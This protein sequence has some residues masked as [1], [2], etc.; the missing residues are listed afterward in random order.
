MNIFF[1]IFIYIF[2]GKKNNFSVIIKRFA[3]FFILPSFAVLVFYAGTN[4]PESFG[5]THFIVGFDHK[6]VNESK[7]CPA[8]S[9]LSKAGGCKT[10]NSSVGTLEDFLAA[11]KTNVKYALF[12]PSDSVLEILKY[13]IDHEKTSI[14][15]AAFMLTD[16]EI[17]KSLISARARGLDVEIVFDPKA[18]K[19]Y[20]NKKIRLLKSKGA[21][22]F[23]YR[24]VSKDPSCQSIEEN[25][26]NIMH[27]KFIVFGNNIFG[28]NIL[29]TGSFNFTY[30]AHKCNQENVLITEDTD[31][32]SR[33]AKQF[34]YMR[35]KLCY[36]YAHKK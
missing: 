18:V 10:E 11:C 9:K 20:N 30:S 36:S 27:H 13:L 6:K 21:K 32:V 7:D 5:K 33:Y 12:S 17:I 4:L 16:Y 1:K 19:H 26:S 22:I 31:L 15:M 14:R 35:E 3:V 28:K 23:V 29:W 8:D 2:G 24:P 34:D 25:M